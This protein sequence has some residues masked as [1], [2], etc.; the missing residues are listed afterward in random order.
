MRL[1]KYT[2]LALGLS[3]FV[4]GQEV[5]FNM[6]AYLQTEL[7][8][9]APWYGDH[10]GGARGIKSGVDLDQDGKQEIW[11]TDYSYGGR[12][13][14]FEMVGTDSLALIWSS[15]LLDTTTYANNKD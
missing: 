4:L 1:L 14:C 5:T 3:T 15:A 2:L 9:H 8:Q 13:H 10:S 6:T 11:A 7:E 12:V